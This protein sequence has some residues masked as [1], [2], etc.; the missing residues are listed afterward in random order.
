MLDDLGLTLSYSH[1]DAAYKHALR[2]DEMRFDAKRADG[3]MLFLHRDPR[4]TVVSSFHEATR[5]RTLFD[6]SISDF[7][8]DPAFGIEKIARFNLGWLQAVCGRPDR[9]SLSYEELVADPRGALGRVSRFFGHAAPADAIAATVQDHGF[10]AMRAREADGTF[11]VQYAGKFQPADPNDPNT[12]KVR[13][14]KI[15]GFADELS[16]EDRRFCDAVMTRLDYLAETAKLT[17]PSSR[18][19]RLAMD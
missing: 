4:D 12:F 9:M 17:P 16:E 1:L 5:R 10:E 15:G 7:I 8:R 14:G 19:A 2:A 13:R 6:G 11:D 3:R 18:D